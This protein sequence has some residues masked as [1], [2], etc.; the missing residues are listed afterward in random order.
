MSNLQYKLM[1][2]GQEIKQLETSLTE[3][4]SQCNALAAQVKQLKTALVEL[5]ESY[6]RDPFK[7][8]ATE[9]AEDGKR[10]SQ[11]H[12]LI[13]LPPAACLAQVRAEAVKA[14]AEM[15]Y[16]E[17]QLPEFRPFMDK[18]CEHLMQRSERIRQGVG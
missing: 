3:K 1:L 18:I 15:L 14:E 10:L 6:C 9:R 11:V 16:K 5:K 13:K 8:T 2:A 12:E 17:P 7:A 4:E